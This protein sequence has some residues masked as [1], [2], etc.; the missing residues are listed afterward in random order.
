M[1]LG[2]LYKKPLKLEN[3]SY[4]SKMFLVFLFFSISVSSFLFKK[5]VGLMMRFQDHDHVFIM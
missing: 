2:S 3:F 5:N 4:G 1:I